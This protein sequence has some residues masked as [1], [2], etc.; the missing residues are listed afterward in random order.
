MAI[1]RSSSS[2]RGGVGG[3][4]ALGQRIERVR[5]P[6]E[7]LGLVEE[8]VVGR[9]VGLDDAVAQRLEVAL[10]VGQRGPQLVGR[11]GD[12]VPP[13]RLLA[14]EAG[15][16]LVERIGEA[17]ELLRAVARDP[18]RV[19]AVGDPAGG[20]ADLGDR[21]GEHAGHDDGQDDARDGGDH[22][23][24]ED[25]GRD[26]LVV[27]RLG[28]LGRVAGLD[29]QRPEDLGADD[30]H[31]DGQDQQPRPRRDERRQRDPGGDPAA[32]HGGAIR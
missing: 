9:P 27:H 1:A 4:V 19:V 24:G 14:L 8:R 5:Q 17:G 26:R 32:D 2:S 20:A 7:A 25:H 31:A 21:A 6:D 29:H 18:G 28:V 22:D 23:R 16:H 3:G 15:R 30:G 12:E 10:Q 13:H 11:V